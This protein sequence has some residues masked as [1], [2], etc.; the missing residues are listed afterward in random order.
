MFDT[1][2]FNQILDGKLDITTFNGKVNYYA[3]HI[4][5]DEIHKT[6]NDER[7]DNL[8]HI[9]T[10]VEPILTPTTVFILDVSRLDEACLGGG[11]IYEAIKSELDKRNKNKSNNVQ[12]AI[13]AETTIINGFTLVTEDSQLFKV[14]V[15]LGGKV[16]DLPSFLGKLS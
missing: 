13:T 3:T 15:E 9:F 2:I 6:K 14:A 8:I 12:D 10:E 1:N 7:R 4:Q 5:V 16:L 11:Q